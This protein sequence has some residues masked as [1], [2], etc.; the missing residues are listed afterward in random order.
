VAGQSHGIIASLS[1]LSTGAEWGCSGTGIPGADGQAL[2]TGAQNTIDIVAGC[3]TPGIAAR[4]CSD[5]VNTETGTGVYSD[6]SLPSQDEIEKLYLNRSAIGGFAVDQ[7]WSS[8]ESAVANRAW[9]FDFN[10]AGL[11]L[12]KDGLH[13]VRAIRYY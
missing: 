5:Y 4:L 13:Y 8:T 3:A 9:I 12:F 6:W 10:G 7:Y 11:Y 1:D 2:G